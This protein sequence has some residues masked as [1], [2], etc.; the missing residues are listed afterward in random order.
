MKKVE[1]DQL[2]KED[3]ESLFN[4]E[5]VWQKVTGFMKETAANRVDEYISA[6]GY[7]V[8]RYSI[9]D[10]SNRDNFLSVENSYQF[11]KNLKEFNRD[12]G[13]LEKSTIKKGE[14]L[15]KKYDDGVVNDDNLQNFC[16]VVAEKLLKIF[17]SEFNCIYDDDFV[18]ENILDYCGDVYGEGA[19]YD[20]SI[21][22][23]FYITCD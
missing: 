13:L 15:I 22:K 14:N 12:F 4:N 21:N 2:T 10:S 5:N 6:I 1:L 23:V 9:S 3:A 11:I 16:N 7:D 8:V 20:R 18:K 17:V 19:Y